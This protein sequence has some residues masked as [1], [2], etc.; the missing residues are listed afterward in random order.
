MPRGSLIIF[1]GEGYISNQ[2]SRLLTSFLI[3]SITKSFLI[4]VWPRMGQ[5]EMKVT[6][7]D[8]SWVLMDMQ[9]MSTLQPVI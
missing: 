9:L 2:T 4:L 5:W 8:V 1:S 7:L 6:S 3:R